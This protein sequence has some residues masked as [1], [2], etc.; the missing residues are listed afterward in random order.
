MLA[1]YFEW[2]V[3][4]GR[5]AEFERLWSEGTKALHAGGSFGSALFRSGDGHFH[6]FARWPDRST[7]DAAIAQRA[8]LGLFVPFQ[9]CIESVVVQRDMDLVDDLWVQP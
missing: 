1:T 9:D 8:S 7:R 6:A 4:P 5:E 2:K 3:K